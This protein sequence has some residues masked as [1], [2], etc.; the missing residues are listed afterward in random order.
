MDK[1]TSKLILTPLLLSLTGLFCRAQS[2]RPSVIVSETPPA[3]RSIEDLNL[4]GAPVT[5]PRISDTLLGDES[6]FRQALF[7]EG[8]LLRANVLPRISMNLLDGP[9]PPDQQV[10][11]GQRPTWITGVNPILTA[12][13]RQVHLHNAQLNVGFGWRW[14]NWNPAGPK[15]VS[16][17]SLYLYKMW[18]YYQVEIKAGYICNDTEFVG[19][20][21]GGSLATGAQGVY[22][23]LPFQA[24]MSYF[25]LTAPSFNLR[26]RGPR[27]T[28]VKIG[29]QRSLDAGGGIATQARNRT[30]FRFIPKGDGLLLINEAGYVR[31]SGRAAH[32]TWFR[33]GYLHNTT[34]YASKVTGHME[35][36]NY[37]AYALL[38]YQLHRSE[39]G[40]FGHGL[41]VGA[42][43]MVAPSRFDAYDRYYEARVYRKAPFHSR[44][45]DVLS[46]VAAY[47]GHSRYVTSSLVTQGKTVWRSSPSMT[48]SYSMH[49]SRGNYLTVG[50]G[51]VR[52]AAITPR[53]AGTLTVTTNWGVYF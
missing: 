34:Q 31:A 24:G 1:R 16:L 28:Y 37:C 47:R 29:A 41:Y 2:T 12:D 42:T 52:G 43:V 33:A 39:S 9:V 8:I 50:V 45:D 19:M 10:Y 48:A 51:Y 7:G 26:V 21:V 49:V 17:T 20:Q 13:L 14:T 15:T 18:R 11:I 38:D 32:Y 3:E 53:I 35:T 6:G 40:A 4:V 36:G 25:P 30:G 5:M 46:V 27:S 23:V 22:A 44:P